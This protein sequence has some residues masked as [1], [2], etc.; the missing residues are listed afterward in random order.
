[1][2]T[3]HGGHWKSD[4]EID[5]KLEKYI[6]LDYAAKHWGDHLRPIQLAMDL[7]A[8]FEFFEDDGLL[9]SCMQAVYATKPWIKQSSQYFPQ[10]VSW[11]HICEHFGL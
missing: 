7:G 10:D 8:V 2:D 11:S 9:L 4:E 5:G 3:F 1:M 6:Y